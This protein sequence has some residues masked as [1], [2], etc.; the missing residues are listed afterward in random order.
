MTEESLL[1]DQGN[2]RL[3]WIMA[4]QGALKTD[5][6]GS[7]DF[8]SFMSACRKGDV[9]KPGS[10]LLSSVAGNE[11]AQALEEFCQSQWDL[12]V[13][14]FKS[15]GQGRGVCNGYAEP[16]SL[17]V[18]R[19]LAIIGAVSRHGS[20]I[21][22]WDLGTA[23]TLDA[24][25][26]AG[27]HL[28]G[29]I[30]PGPATMLRALDRDTRLAAP[31]SLANAGVAP[32]RTTAACIENGVFAAQLGALNQ[33]M[34]NTQELLGNQPKLIVTG[35]AAGEILPLLD[36]EHIHDPWLVFRGM[37]VQGNL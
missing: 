20:P 18:D 37:L 7:G 4:S 19:W 30:Y 32:G 10:V 2:T 22:V 28:G 17:G 25:N 5:S 12:K 34:R 26:Q 6:A 21:I 27:Q 29:M 33:F 35:G 23:T 13:Q 36:F 16:E 3:K 8:K 9:G 14:S 24:V 1:I 11:A 15:A 31:A